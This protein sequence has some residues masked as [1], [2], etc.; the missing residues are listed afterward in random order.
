MTKISS[1]PLQT[2]HRTGRSKI[3]RLLSPRTQVDRA[4][5]RK[6]LKG[7]ACGAVTACPVSYFIYQHTKDV[8]FEDK[9]KTL[10]DKGV[11]HD[12]ETALD[13]INE[14]YNGIDKSYPNDAAAQKKAANTLLSQYKEYIFSFTY[15]RSKSIKS[16]ILNSY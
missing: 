13:T 16:K 12:Q 6:F 15:S 5:R 10:I 1:R 2:R 3:A 8:P 4:G 7:L 9:F 14:L 11:V